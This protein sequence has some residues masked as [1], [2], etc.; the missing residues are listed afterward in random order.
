MSCTMLYN[1]YVTIRIIY[2]PL[3]VI[4][5]ACLVIFSVLTV[6]VM[7]REIRAKSK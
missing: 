1:G 5:Y 3:F 4:F 2:L 7:A 6:N